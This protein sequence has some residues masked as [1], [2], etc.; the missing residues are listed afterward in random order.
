M[1]RTLKVRL[2]GYPEAVLADDSVLVPTGRTTTGTD[3][4][5]YVSRL[6]QRIQEALQH[7]DGTPRRSTRLLVGSRVLEHTQRIPETGEV[8]LLAA[9]PC[10]G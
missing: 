5:D 7:R 6:D 3:V 8:V 10:D 9:L 4:I 2:R 1:S